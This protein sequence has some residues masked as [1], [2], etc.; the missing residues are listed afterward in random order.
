MISMITLAVADLE[1]SIAFYEAIGFSRVPFDS[2]TIAFFD[3]G[4]PQLALF[5]REALARDAG[6]P[7]E[8]SGFSGITLSQNFD[9]SKQVDAQFS[10][11]LASGGT[12]VKVPEPVFWGGYSGYFRDPDG[13][14]LEV[15]C[16]SGE[17]KNE[18]HGGV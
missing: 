14:L 4:G 10:L 15:A 3:A 5:P 1:K 12:E 13:H 17:Y 16:G 2:D 18:Q 9:T 7:A 11:A 6:I 8:G